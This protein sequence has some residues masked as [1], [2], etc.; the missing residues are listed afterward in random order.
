MPRSSPCPR[1][2]PAAP[3]APPACSPQR[4]A[5]VPAEDRDPGQAAR[6]TLLPGPAHLLLDDVGTELHLY[7]QVVPF[8]LQLLQL[9]AHLLVGLWGWGVALLVQLSKD[10]LSSHQTLNSVDLAD[11][12]S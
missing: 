7:I 3:S 8:F 2:Q 4:A 9:K 5:S 11:S 6:R 1:P 10:Q 12:I